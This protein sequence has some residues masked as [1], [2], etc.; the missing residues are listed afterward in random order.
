MRNFLAVALIGILVSGCANTTITNLTPSQY[1]RNETGVYT[2]EVELTTK[3]QSL[4]HHTITPTV[5]IGLDSY[6]MRRTLKTENRWEGTIPVAKG[7][8]LVSYHFKFDYDYSRF[9]QPGRD[10]KLSPGY[11]L[12]IVEK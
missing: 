7:K 4:Q 6:P 12:K 11:E 1:V 10:S 5:V 8:D 3:Q 2:V 9:G